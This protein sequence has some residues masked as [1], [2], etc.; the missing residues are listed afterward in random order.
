MN[1]FT[2][3]ARS[4]VRQHEHLR[5]QDDPEST[6]WPI[7]V[8][9]PASGRRTRSPTRPLPPERAEPFLPT[10]QS[11]IDGKAK[12]EIFAMG[13]RNDYTIH[14]DKK[15]DAITTAWVG[16]DQGTDSTTWGEAKTENATMMNSRGQLRL[17]VL[18]GR[19][20]LGLSRQAA[21]T[22]P[23]AAASRPTSRTTFPARSAAAPT[24]KPARSS[25]AADR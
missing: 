10:D 15:T 9:R 22:P 21:A 12:P 20:P 14:I 16:P 25:T 5:R 7:R 19:Q 24:G 11:V 23:A 3:D 8:P 17:A 2:S 13:V 1:A 4:D 6:R 18:P